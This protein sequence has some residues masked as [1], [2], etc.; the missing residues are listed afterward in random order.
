MI[1]IFKFLVVSIVFFAILG[2]RFAIKALKN[3]CGKDAIRPCYPHSPSL[4]L[5]N[6]KSDVTRIDLRFKQSK[7]G[8]GGVTHYSVEIQQGIT[9][10]FFTKD[11]DNRIEVVHSPQLCIQ[12]KCVNYYYARKN[13]GDIDV[14]VGSAYGGGIIEHM[15]LQFPQ[16]ESTTN[17]FYYRNNYGDLKVYNRVENECIYCLWPGWMDVYRDNSLFT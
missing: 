7:L 3:Y 9:F 11:I 15:I 10:D 5:F 12:N 17:A 1:K 14:F 4:F 13:W 8:V 6:D 16:N 2:P